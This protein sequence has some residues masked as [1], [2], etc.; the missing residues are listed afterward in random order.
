MRPNRRIQ[1]FL[2]IFLLAGPVVVL[3]TAAQTASD[4][5]EE[6]ARE[7]ILL[8]TSDD[9]EQRKAAAE[10]LRSEHQWAVDGL[11]QIILETV[12]EMNARLPQRLDRVTYFENVSFF[13]EQLLYH[14]RFLFEEG[15]LTPDQVVQLKQELK[16]RLLNQICPNASMAGFLAFGRV[17]SV[18]TLF[19]DHTSF[20]TSSIDWEDCL[21]KR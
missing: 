6:E 10:K 9:Q 21:D 13:G 5:R 2:L 11:D 7:L 4:L 16:R 8:L 12:D 19:A 1:S 3:A 18:N 17:I 15:D 20:F 14:M